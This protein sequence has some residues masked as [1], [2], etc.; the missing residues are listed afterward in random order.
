[1]FLP[2]TDDELS[3]RERIREGLGRRATGFAVALLLE[4]LLL[5]LLLT[6]G[7]A[8]R[9]RNT[10]T[11]PVATFDV[12]PAP[13]EAPAPTPAEQEKPAPTALVRPQPRQPDTPAP[14][15]V[16]T[17]TPVPAFIPLPRDQ[18][19]PA[20]ITPPV[21]RPPPPAPSNEPAYGPADTGPRGEP[22]SVRVGT[23][24]DG[25]PLYAA[26]WY[27]EPYPDELRGYLSTADRP[28]SGT[29]MCR[30]APDWRVEDCVPVSET[31]RGSNYARAVLA[32]SWQFKVRPAQFG[33]KALIG[34]WVR[35]TIYDEDQPH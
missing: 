14:Q 5:V 6:L 9:I 26:K 23:A 21:R 33:G 19:A 29:I 13:E 7:Q 11:L 16:P 1:M 35:I 32:A 34:A 28:G 8:T 2:A 4:A 3:W 25:Q 31:P 20:D 18:M 17:I 10:G 15:P 12:S 30:T 27:R 24:P 22:D